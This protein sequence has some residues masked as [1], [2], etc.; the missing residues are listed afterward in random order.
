M[1]EQFVYEVEVVPFS[2]KPLLKLSTS[3]LKPLMF[4]ANCSLMLTMMTLLQKLTLMTML[5]MLTPKETSS[6]LQAHLP[7]VNCFNWMP[8]PMW[9]HL[10]V[11][12]KTVSS[13]TTRLDCCLMQL[14]LREQDRMMLSR[15]LPRP[16]WTLILPAE[17]PH[18]RIVP[19][20]SNPILSLL[21]KKLGPYF[22]TSK[23]TGRYCV[24]DGAVVFKNSDLFYTNV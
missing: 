5:H 10:Q 6:K 9:W 11:S 3:R 21:Q 15:Q 12:G 14:S 18:P 24:H 22:I 2:S 16:K 17:P 20:R 13:G 7:P 23:L 1:E 4:E 8:P 19:E